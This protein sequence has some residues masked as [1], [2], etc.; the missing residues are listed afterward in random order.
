LN[1]LG[2]RKSSCARPN[3]NRRLKSRGEPRSAEFVVRRRRALRRARGRR[4]LVDNARKP[5]PAP[6]SAK[7]VPRTWSG[8]I[9]S[10]GSKPPIALT[11]PAA[12]AFGLGGIGAG[13]QAPVGGESAEGGDRRHAFERFSDSKFAESVDRAVV[14]HTD[15]RKQAQVV[16]TGEKGRLPARDR[17]QPSLSRTRGGCATTSRNRPR[18]GA[19]TFVAVLDGLDGRV[20]VRGA[21]RHR[22]QGLLRFVGA[23]RRAVWPASQP[24]S[25]S[26]RADVRLTPRA[27]SAP[28]TRLE[29]PG[30]RLDFCRPM[31]NKNRQKTER[32][33]REG[34]T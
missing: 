33:R 13:R 16:K 24:R 7:V 1:A 31:M 4:H 14:L 22:R 5:N 8:E 2:G 17:S 18:D 21:L 10:R 12:N 34:E 19:T 3:A 26:S 32:R 9:L 29:R 27:R 6:P 28:P 25:I 30:A 15:P 20:T 23:I 11:A